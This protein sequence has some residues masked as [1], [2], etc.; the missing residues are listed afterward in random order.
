LAHKVIPVRD[1]MFS[2]PQ[3][4]ERH[5]RGYTRA[6]LIDDMTAGAAVHMAHQI[7]QLEPGGTLEQNVL[8]YE[9]SI[10]VLEGA[11]DFMIDGR[12]Y[13]MT[14]GDYGLVLVGASHAFRN[15]GRDRARWMEMIAPQPLNPSVGQDTFF[16]GEYGWPD[17]CEPFDKGDARTR[18]VGHFADGQL[19]PPGNLQMDGY[20]GGGAY[21][22][23]Q[24]FLVDRHFGSAHMALFVVEFAKGGGGT[25]HTHPFEESYYFVKGF[26]DCVF[27]GLEY[28]VGPGTLCWSGVGAKHQIFTRGDDPVRFI[29][30]QTPQPPARQAFRFDNEWAEMRYRYPD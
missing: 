14:A 11:F 28:V 1:H 20:S 3:G 8:A 13:Q 15:R 24:K 17:A 23:S 30:T 21:G 4:Y 26:A 29:E 12:A 10:F 25:H 16:V 5:A 18:F 2:V 9:K 7:V 27:E 22:I 19:P 6:S